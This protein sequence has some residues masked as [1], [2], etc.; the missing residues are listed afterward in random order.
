MANNSF[1]GLVATMLLVLLGLIAAFV[2]TFFVDNG[3]E[4]A[5][6]AKGHFSASGA[7]MRFSGDTT[8]VRDVAITLGDTST[9]GGSLKR[10]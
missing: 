9:S 4:Y 6:S 10:S 1:H 5:I 2:A 7:L 3:Y 8:V